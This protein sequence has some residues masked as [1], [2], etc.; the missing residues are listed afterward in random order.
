MKKLFKNQIMQNYS[1]PNVMYFYTMLSIKYKS[2]NFGQGFPNFPLPEILTKSLD[3]TFSLDP[4]KRVN[5]SFGTEL[6]LK[7]LEKEYNILFDLKNKLD[8][9]KNFIVSCGA[10]AIL[11]YI[12][13]SLKKNDEIIIIEPFFPWYNIQSQMF[14]KKINYISLKISEKEIYL[15]HK[16]L[17]SLINNKTKYIIINSPQNPSGKVLK[18]KDFEKFSKLLKKFPNLNII[19]DEVYDQVY[20][21]KGDFP[22]ISKYKNLFERVISIYSGGK[23]FS[24]TGWRIGWAVGPQHLI[25]KLKEIQLLTN[26]QTNSV[27]M[28]HIALALDSSRNPY[29]GFESYFDYYKNFFCDKK[30]LLCEILENCDLGFKVVQ[31]EGGHFVLCDISESIRK[32]PVGY[33]YK[34]N[35]ER[36]LEGK[37]KFLGKFEDW[38]E[39]QQVDYVPDEAMCNFLTI[40]KGVTPIP[41]NPFYNPDN[42]EDDDMHFRFIRFAICKKTEDIIELGKVLK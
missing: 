7:S 13:N 27:H 42:L 5:Y 15:D 2:I 22:R 1:K 20:Y 14:G 6:L 3:K 10:T 4:L 34:E 16:K 35:S 41:C 32:I 28:D 33:F 38:R 36:F 11:G 17:S 9:K 19:S 8:W 40:E 21:Q 24:C 30:N 39:L 26:N 25:T 18:E 37:D 31:P 23:T 29:L 12:C